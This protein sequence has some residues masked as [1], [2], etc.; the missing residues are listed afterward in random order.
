MLPFSDYYKNSHMVDGR[1]SVCK[2]CSKK[3]RSTKEYRESQKLKMRIKRK[4]NHDLKEKERLLSKKYREENLDKIKENL[5]LYRLE[6][7]E[8]ISLQRKEYRE[9]NKLEIKEYRD[10]Y[11]EEN[12]EECR[13]R[14]REWHRINKHI[15]NSYTAKRR[16]S[17]R[18]ACP[19]WVCQDSIKEVYKKARELTEST[20]IQYHVD[21]IVPLI[22]DKVS[23]LHVLANLRVVPYYE[24]LQK[25]N[26]LIEDIV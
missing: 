20:G 7:K 21:H 17:K 5:R 4:D 16:F 25:S 12:I 2:P 23:G 14:V 9:K 3:E 1:L 10:K 22:N 18:R 13:E 26:K 19:N 11:R 15:S 8:R 24:N 6:N